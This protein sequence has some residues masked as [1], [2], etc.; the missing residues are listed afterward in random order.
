ME[1]LITSWEAMN[2]AKEDGQEVAMILLDFEKASN[3]IAW[4]FVIGMLKA[5]GFLEVYCKWI[6]VL[7]KDA[8]IVIDVNGSLSEPIVLQ[9][10]IR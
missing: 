2:W 4:G 5:F 1:N 7:F 10:S 6:N 3:R 9:R 8:S